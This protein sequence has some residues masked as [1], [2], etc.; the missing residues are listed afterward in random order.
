[1]RKNHEK[2]PEMTRRDALKLAGALTL[3][4]VIGSRSAMAGETQESSSQKSPS[5]KKKMRI[6][7]IGGGIAGTTAAFRLSRAIAYP[8][9]MLFEPSER[10][11]WYQPGL[12]MVGT[13]V[14]KTDELKLSRQE[15]LPAHTRWI[16]RSVTSIDP[17]KNQLV[18]SEG[19]SYAYDILVITSGAKLYYDKIEGLG[20]EA[21]ATLEKGEQMMGWEEDPTIASIYTLGGAQRL[22]P[23]IKQLPYKVVSLKKE[24]FEIVFYQP[25]IHI[26]SP[27]AAKTALLTVLEE[28]EKAGIIPGQMRV[29]WV[30]QDGKLSQSPAYD[31]MYKKMLKKRG[32]VFKKAKLLSLDREKQK[33]TF[34]DLSGKEFTLPYDFIHIAPPMG[35]DELFVKSGL[36][37]AKGWIDTD[38]KTLKHRRFDNIFALGDAADTDGMKVATAVS[39]Q[40]KV[41]TDNI[42]TLDDGKKR[43]ARYDGYGRDTI[44][45][46][47]KKEAM[48]EAFGA[49]G[50]PQSVM[51]WM[52][53]TQCHRFYWYE[54]LHVDKP[55]LTEAVMKGWA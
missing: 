27:G 9:I 38:P 31:A 30:S 32:V 20:G 24:P 55:F 36:T 13:G 51:P 8:E 29:T 22:H 54:A 18:D 50:T 7:I 39:D 4:G 5:G 52:N 47:L 34:D 43:D 35:A 15:Y 44:L 42:R 17:E 26:K 6:A 3:S 46:P 23:Q 40:V 10:S 37:N 45:C 1:M 28:L 41:V 11:V 12:T 25:D 21:V 14:W 33:A 49:K 16:K 19:K 48:Y 2:K 53:P